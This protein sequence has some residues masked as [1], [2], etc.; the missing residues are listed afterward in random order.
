MGSPRNGTYV[1]RMVAKHGTE[2]HSAYHPH[3]LPRDLLRLPSRLFDPLWLRVEGVDKGK[4]DD[5]LAADGTG[6]VDFFQ[7]SFAPVKVPAGIAS[8]GD[9]FP[10]A[11]LLHWHGGLRHLHPNMAATLLSLLGP[12]PPA[13]V[14]AALLRSPSEPSGRVV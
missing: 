4:V 12:S 9:L 1:A 5:W 11:V 7:R 6:R 3:R 8:L 14:W 2:D 13:R 10:G